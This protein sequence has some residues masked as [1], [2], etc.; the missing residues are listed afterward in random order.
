[1]FVWYVVKNG[2][3]VGVITRDEPDTFECRR[4]AKN[5]PDCFVWSRSIMGWA[6]MDTNK[7][8]SD[9]WR[10]G[11]PPDVVIMANMLRGE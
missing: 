11:T 4:E 10:A 8:G 6:S 5:Y 1:M 3:I 9:I 7:I 2:E